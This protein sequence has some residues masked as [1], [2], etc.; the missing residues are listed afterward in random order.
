MKKAPC[1]AGPERR[2]LYP[3]RSTINRAPSQV[4]ET[5]KWMARKLGPDKLCEMNGLLQAHFNLEKPQKK[6]PSTQNSRSLKKTRPTFEEL[7]RPDPELM[8]I[9]EKRYSYAGPERR[10]L[11]MLRRIIDKAASWGVKE[12]MKWMARKLGPVRLYEVNEHLRAGRF[13]LV[14]P[15]KNELRIRKAPRSLEIPRPTF[16]DL[17]QGIDQKLWKTLEMCGNSLSFVQIGKHF[18]VSDSR[19]ESYHN[20]AREIIWRRLRFVAPVSKE[21]FEKHRMLFRELGMQYPPKIKYI[22]QYLQPKSPFT[23]DLMKCPIEYLNFSAP[24]LGHVQDIL[25]ANGVRTV[26]DLVL[27]TEYELMFMDSSY[28]IGPANINKIRTRLAKYGLSLGM[29]NPD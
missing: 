26:K 10:K 21:C 17:L 24:D 28:S 11:Y 3:L 1:Y 22:R 6:E 15:K 9:F 19:A 18:N 13:D 25:I 16:D 12:T 5:L 14:N 29:S 27:K 2:K 23:L 8:K 4:K 7:I 20:R